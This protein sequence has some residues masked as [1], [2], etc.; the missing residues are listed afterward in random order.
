M[1][2]QALLENSSHKITKRA[3]LMIKAISVLERV[4][5]TLA[6]LAT[7]GSFSSIYSEMGDSCLAFPSSTNEIWRKDDKNTSVHSLTA[8]FI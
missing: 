4:A 5:L 7:G 2:F 8:E 1:I 3:T 6:F